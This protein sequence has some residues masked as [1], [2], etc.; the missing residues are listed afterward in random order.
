MAMRRIGLFF[1]GL[2][3]F[4][5]WAMTA[6]AASAAAEAS[7]AVTVV[8]RPGRSAGVYEWRIR[9]ADEPPPSADH[10]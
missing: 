6:P 2:V 4:A 5:L 3:G 7:A 8:D 10:E 9:T 1:L